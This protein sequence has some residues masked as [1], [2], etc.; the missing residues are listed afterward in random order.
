MLNIEHEN[1]F[2][3][4]SSAIT[5]CLFEEI[6]QSTITNNSSS[7]STIIHVQPLKKTSVSNYQ[8][9]ERKR[10]FNTNQGQ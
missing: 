8:D 6:C 10:M 2:Q 3:H 9:R 7:G 4:Q 1:R 5:L